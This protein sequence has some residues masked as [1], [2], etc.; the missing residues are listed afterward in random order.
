M[1]IRLEGGCRDIWSLIVRSDQTCF[2]YEE[3]H[4]QDATAQAASLSELECYDF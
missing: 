4:N 1:T 3:L 2:S